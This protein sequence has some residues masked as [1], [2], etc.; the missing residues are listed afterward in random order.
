MGRWQKTRELLWWEGVVAFIF[1]PSILSAER[2][3][4]EMEEAAAAVAVGKLRWTI[5]ARC[6]CVRCLARGIKGAK[7]TRERRGGFGAWLLPG[8]SSQV[9]QYPLLSERA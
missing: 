9:S 8:Q 5:T 6:M 2:S 7:R 3:L 1:L 4:R